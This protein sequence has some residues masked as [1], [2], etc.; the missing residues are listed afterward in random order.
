M[1]EKMAKL[2]V[3][4]APGGLRFQPVDSREVAARLVQLALGEPVGRVADLAG[5]TVHEMAD[6]IRSYLQATGN[7]RL[8]MP[9][10]MPGKIGRAYRAGRT[11][12]RYAHPRWLLPG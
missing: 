9:I 11:P 4:P 7:R 6:L 8:M 5:P 12:P 1:A 10:R 3:I 2:P